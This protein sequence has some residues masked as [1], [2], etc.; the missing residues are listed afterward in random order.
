ML[1]FLVKNYGQNGNMEIQDTAYSPLMNDVI[2]AA[3]EIGL[4]E[5]DFNGSSQKGS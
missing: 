5:T 4:N 1:N 3:R 2:E